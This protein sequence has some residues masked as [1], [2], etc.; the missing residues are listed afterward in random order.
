MPLFIGLPVKL[1]SL[2]DTGRGNLNKVFKVL[3][4]VLKLIS[5]TYDFIRLTEA[6]G[7]VHANH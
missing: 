4:V 3:K 1:Q 7:S 2:K 5:S 6:T